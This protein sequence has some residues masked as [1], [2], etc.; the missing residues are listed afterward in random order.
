MKGTRFLNKKL[1]KTI[2]PRLYIQTI[3]SGNILLPK[4][5]RFKIGERNRFKNYTYRV[6]LT[7]I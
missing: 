2:I 4:A 3:W 1:T 7:F 5:S 6:K